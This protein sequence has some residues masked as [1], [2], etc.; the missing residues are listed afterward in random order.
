MSL[1]YRLMYRVGFSPW[2]TGQ[3]PAE[4]SVLVERDDALPPGRALDIGCGTGSQAV[5]LAQN[6]W[7][8]TG[9]DAVE[10]PLRRARARASEAGVTVDWIRADV[11]QL[12]DLSLVPG[13]T[14]VFDRG[15]YHGLSDQERS[16][17]A[18]SVTELAAPGGTLLMMAF[19][20]NRVLIGPSGAD[21]DEIVARFDHWELASWQPDTGPP[22]AGPM[23]H[24]PRNWYRLHRR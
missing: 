21:Q 6:R 1:V 8:V 12:A 3:V 20:C 9:I 13:F 7:A 22:P 16:A 2:D 23:R 10:R 4:L 5:Y 18:A 14:L 19:A 15:C 11:A 24:V 17:Y